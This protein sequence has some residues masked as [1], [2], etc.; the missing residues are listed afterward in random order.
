M[1]GNDGYETRNMTSDILSR[2]NAYNHYNT[3]QGQECHGN[4]ENLHD[5]VAIGDPRKHYDNQKQ[6][7]ESHW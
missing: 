4:D 5:Y 6:D 2:R 3:Y 1:V 7:K